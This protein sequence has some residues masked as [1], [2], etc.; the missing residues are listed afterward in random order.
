METDA[1]AAV[2]AADKAVQD[3]T[4]IVK[5]AEEVATASAKLAAEAKAALDNDPDNED[6][7]KA[8][9]DAQLKAEAD[10][11]VVEDAKQ[12]LADA[13]V[14]LQEKQQ[15]LTKASA[16]AAAAKGDAE[17]ASLAVKASQAAADVAAKELPGIE[18]A[19]ADA[20]AALA[21]PE[22]A[23]NEAQ[24]KRDNLLQQ[25]ENERASVAQKQTERD[26][27]RAILDTAEQSLADARAT[28]AR[29]EAAHQAK[30]ATH[31]FKFL[32]VVGFS[33]D[34]AGPEAAESIRAGSY[35]RYIPNLLQVPRH[36]ADWS[37][38]VRELMRE[39]KGRFDTWV[40]WENPDIDDA[41][42]N[43]PP[44]RYAE[45]LTAFHRWVKLYQPEAK[46][47]AGGFNFSKM[48]DYL[49]RVD[50]PS[51]LPFDEISVQM[52]LGELAE[53][54]DVEGFLDEL[55]DKLRLR[56][57]NRLVRIQEL[58]WGIAD[59]LSPAEQAAYHA[60][61]A[62]ILDSRGATPHQFNLIN[63]GFDFEGY[64]VFYRVA[65]GNTPSLQSHLPY[66]VPKPAYFALAQT[67]KFLDA[68]TFV[69]S[70][71]L[72]DRGLQDNRAF[73]YRNEQQELCVALW[74]AVAGAREYRL[75]ETWQTATASDVFGFPI[76]LTNSIR[77]SPL[78]TFIKLPANASLETVK[79]EL[80]LLPAVDGSYPVLA[81]LYLDEPASLAPYQYSSTGSTSRQTRAGVLPGG[82]K[83]RETFVAG[84]ES[85][86][87]RF[88]VNRQGDALLRKRWF[89][90]GAGGEL[91]LRLNDGPPLAWKLTAGQG[92]EPGARESTIVLRDCQAGENTL[93]IAYKTPGNGSG[94]R[95][96]PLATNH[97]PLTRWGAINTRQSVGD[98][99]HHTSVV[100]TPLRIG[101][102][103]YE[104]GLG[105]HATSFIEYPLAGQFDAFEVTVGVDG[106]AEGR[107]SVVFRVFIDGQE[108][109]NSQLITGFSKPLTLKV[110]KLAGA[111]RM[112]LSVTDAGD[113]DK[114][115][116]ANWVDGKLILKQK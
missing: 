100:G 52:N 55:N 18:K 109:A 63:T 9:A 115:D 66:H 114:N 30:L 38:F 11:K 41:P 82:R 45:L 95:L 102:Q 88:V 93:R 47:V 35:T 22:K 81:D 53:H 58:D 91:E 69:A 77:V 92:N 37:L 73:I 10:A 28:H 113:G 65:Y 85:E 6:L 110:D 103:T 48:L 32:P 112:I 50:Q 76:A 98:F 104:E 68:W 75:P 1:K 54:A 111:E 7:K 87:F 39:Y 90:D 42:Q 19:A 89:F 108:R 116:L 59:Y 106:G 56:D 3:A 61:A 62:L 67:R 17:K 4:A 72:A 44:Q 105:A 51:Q 20:R 40:F 74:R 94:Y 34:W 13:Q 83:L 70:T 86:S 79:Q 26:A 101:S 99:L 33:A 97:V 78:P 64:G 2:E 80:R 71:H 107:G 36:A 43:I 21:P 96:E 29:A 57:L 25:I 14:I 12:K 24:A 49:D 15:Q 60:R 46:V 31:G 84:L 16:A 27:A 8:F 5:K 23:R